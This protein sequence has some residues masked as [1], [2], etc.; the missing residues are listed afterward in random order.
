MQ[1]ENISKDLLHLQ[2]IENSHDF[3]LLS[4][5]M[6]YNSIDKFDIG[7]VKLSLMATHPF[8]YLRGTAERFFDIFFE[9]LQYTSFEFKNVFKDKKLITACT[10]DTHVGNFGFTG[11]DSRF[12]TNDFDEYLKGNPFMDVLRYTSSL[13][14]F[15]DD[16]NHKISQNNLELRVLKNIENDFE[17][18]D[19][20]DIL[21]IVENNE[22]FFELLEIEIYE[23]E[24]LSKEEIKDVFKQCIKKGIKNR[25]KM[26]KY[27]DLEE[28]ENSFFKHYFNAIKKDEK[29]KFSKDSNMQKFYKKSKEKFDRNN[30]LEK[31]TKLIENKK[32]VFDLENEKII[33]FSEKK[34]EKIKQRVKKVLDKDTTVV[35]I[36][37]RKSA[38][39]GSS[40]LNRFYILIKKLHKDEYQLLEMKEQLKPVSLNFLDEFEEFFDI[41]LK[42][43][44][45]KKPARIH[46]KGIKLILSKKFDKNVSSVTYK[47]KS[48]ILKTHFD[49]KQSFDEVKIF[50][51]SKSEKDINKF[52]EEYVK[53]T[54]IA[55]ANSHLEGLKVQIPNF[56]ENK[57]H[58]KEYKKI[59][60][61]FQKSM[62][63]YE[64]DKNLFRFLKSMTKNLSNLIFEDY[65]LFA[66]QYNQYSGY[67]KGKILARLEDSKELEITELKG[68]LKEIIYT[69]EYLNL[70]K[71]TEKEIYRKVYNL[72]DNRKYKINNKSLKEY[73]VISEVKEQL[74]S[75]VFTYLNKEK[76]FLDM[77]QKHKKAVAFYSELKE[78]RRFKNIL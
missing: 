6:K 67:I 45:D 41:D 13:K 43:Y 78:L 23:F 8:K 10:N 28:L 58:L 14:F 64:D 70:L 24:A 56:S 35:D 50:K 2:K 18:L 1:T 32:R 27:L 72:I 26:K 21:D 4:K 38:G 52:L 31:Y 36:T 55:L 16:I 65:L 68:I 46:E 77:T 3:E 37:K 62:C 74:L 63:K 66:K 39:V 48:Y 71:S 11:D 69:N 19:K 54:A 7:N 12:I 57:T 76:P 44:I 20:Q 40:H 34:K 60:Q 61:N 17:K 15:I 30:Q 42:E 75:V 51:Y 25:V 49:S 29:L 22:F 73:Y 47:D 59:K 33:D 9:S 53:Y 5:I